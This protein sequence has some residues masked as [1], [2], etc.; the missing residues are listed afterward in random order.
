M[1]L[2]P[3]PPPP[4]L[5]VS[6]LAGTTVYDRG[7]VPAA[8]AD[9]LREA[10][11]PFDPAEITAWRGASKREVL[12][13]LLGRDGAP[14]DVV[15]ERLPL[16][17]GRFHALLAERLALA[18]P[19]SLPGVGETFA[20][21]RAA[22]IR[23]ALTT[24]FDRALVEQLLAVVDWAELVDAWVSSD[25]VL[26]G[27]PAPDMIVLAMRRCGVTDA[28]RIAVVGTLG[29]TSRPPG[30]RAPGGASA[31]SRARTTARRSRRPRTPISSTR[32]A[33]CR[34]SGSGIERSGRRAH[35]ERGRRAEG[36]QH[37]A[38]TLGQLLECGQLLGGRVGVQGEVQ[39]DR[40]E[41][42]RCLFAHAERATKV[43][44]PFGPDLA[45][46]HR[47]VQGGGHRAK[48][49]PGAG[50]EGLQQQV[51]RTGLEP[52]AAGRRMQPR[53]NHRAPGVDVAAHRRLVQP[54]GGAE[55]HHGLLGR[56]AIRF[57]QG[58]LQGTKVFRTHGGGSGIE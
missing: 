50:H 51:P 4:E 18:A 20:R 30:T 11:V 29:S 38:V 57:L 58:G 26:L 15:A 25:D 53:L 39:P 24:G 10:A 55:G 44:L 45:A 33:I 16:V 3:T 31:S 6:D 43:E 36:L 34:R 23:I 7:E 47:E 41:P 46:T 42:H 8:F 5:L 21:L 9:A 1:L 17:Y 2:V 56:G 14:A 52:G 12:G 40:A 35:A 48:R 22:G 27:R 54:A 19:V 37:D 32:C 28:D 49:Y 13:R